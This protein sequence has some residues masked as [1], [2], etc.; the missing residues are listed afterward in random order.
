MLAEL[1]SHLNRS[2]NAKECVGQT[3]FSSQ[4]TG[5]PPTTFVYLYSWA[6]WS[7]WTEKQKFNGDGPLS[8]EGVCICLN[9]IGTLLFS[10]QPIF[11]TGHPV[12][13]MEKLR[14]ILSTLTKFSF[15]YYP[16]CLDALVLLKIEVQSDK[17]SMTKP[18]TASLLVTLPHTRGIIAMTWSSISFHGCNLSWKYILFFSTLGYWLDLLGLNSSSTCAITTAAKQLQS[19]YKCIHG[20]LESPLMFQ[21]MNMLP[22]LRPLVSFLRYL[23]FHSFLLL[24]GPLES[25]Q[26]WFCYLYY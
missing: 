24:G 17:N 14:F 19:P 23:L 26:I 16:W 22:M 6:K 20:A 9:H 4:S 8:L 5:Y 7:C 12:E 10:L 3:C 15:K 13:S 25:W 11:L 2:D 1:V 18:F 21:F